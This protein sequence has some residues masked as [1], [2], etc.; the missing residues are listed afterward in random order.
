MSAARAGQLETWDGQ[1]EESD[2]IDVVDVKYI[3]KHHRRQKY[4]CSYG[5]CIETAPGPLKLF[6][7]ARYSVAFAISIA[8]PSTPTTCRWSAR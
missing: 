8:I 5:A 3:L 6:P 2:E 4:R 1:F 7:G